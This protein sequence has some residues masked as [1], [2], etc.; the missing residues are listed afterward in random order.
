[1]ERREQSAKGALHFR[2]RRLSRYALGAPARD[3]WSEV[4]RVPIQNAQSPSGRLRGRSAKD[5][6]ATA[7][8]GGSEST[9]PFGFSGWA[10]QG[11]SPAVAVTGDCGRRYCLWPIFFF[12]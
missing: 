1:M 11:A 12:I 4:I 2:Q 5:P 10:R 6:K 9:A 8:C 7:I 3:G